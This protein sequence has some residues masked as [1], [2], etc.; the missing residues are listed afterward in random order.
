MKQVKIKLHELMGK[1]KIRSINKLSIETGITRQTLT[2]MYNEESTQLDFATI[3]KLCDFFDCDVG[4][5]LV[6]V[7]EPEQDSSGESE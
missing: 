5:L 7:D 4:E 1:H 6:L 3:G 2:R